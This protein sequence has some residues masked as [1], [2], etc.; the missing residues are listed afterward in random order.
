VLGS[1]ALVGF[2]AYVVA[3]DDAFNTLE[4]VI[5]RSGTM[6]SVP[7]LIDW[8]LRPLVSFN[9][10]GVARIVSTLALGVAWLAVLRWMRPGSPSLYSGAFLFMTLLVGFG[11]AFCFPW[12]AVWFIPIAALLPGS[13]FMDASVVM[14]AAALGSY[15]EFPWST[16][17]PTGQFIW[18]ITV[19]VL[20]FLYLFLNRNEI[21]TSLHNTNGRSLPATSKSR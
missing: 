18:L 7:W 19:L 11:V 14:S 5:L 4:T 2:I 16:T 15:A 9:P 6:R 20:P 1:L 17:G 13:R 8:P 21:E 3:K 10:A 12:Y